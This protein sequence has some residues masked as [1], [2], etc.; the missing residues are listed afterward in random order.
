MISPDRRSKHFPFTSIVRRPPQEI[1]RITRAFPGNQNAL[2]IHT[3][4]DVSKPPTLITNQTVRGDQRI[5]EK[6]LGSIVIDHRLYRTNLHTIVLEFAKI[7]QEHRQPI[8]WL[9]H[10]LARGGPSQQQHQIRVQRPT[11]PDLL[12]IDPVVIPVAHGTGAQSS[13]IGT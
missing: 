13:R 2:C 9:F 4:E 1:P 8:T 6:Y 10:I 3:I 7:N 12:P 11:G 5:V